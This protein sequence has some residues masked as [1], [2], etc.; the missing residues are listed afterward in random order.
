MWPAIQ[1]WRDGEALG[2]GDEPVTEHHLPYLHRIG[3]AAGVDQLRNLAKEG[4][5]DAGGSEHDQRAGV[6]RV[7]VAEVVHRARGTSRWSPRRS[8][9]LVP[10]T[11]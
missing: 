10:S 5:A 3:P 9:R 2:R 4:R 11:V 7:E 8:S 6:A 1:R